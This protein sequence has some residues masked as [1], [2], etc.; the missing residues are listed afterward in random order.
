[1]LAPSTAP[2]ENACPEALLLVSKTSLADPLFSLDGEAM[3]TYPS[4]RQR[5]SEL[6]C[7]Q[8]VDVRQLRPGAIWCSVPIPNTQRQD[9]GWRQANYQLGPGQG[10]LER[11]ESMA[12]PGE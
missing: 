8:P 3:L 1:M 12:T 9:P 5:R 2:L 11:M 10:Q 7:E 4:P 6:R